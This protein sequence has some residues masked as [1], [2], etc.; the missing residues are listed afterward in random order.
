MTGR[1]VLV[2]GGR[3]YDDWSLVRRTLNRLHEEQPF[4]LVI[5]GAAGGADGL[6]RSW[7]FSRQITVAE[8]PA[9][10]RGLGKKAG[11]LRNGEMI[12]LMKPDVIIAFPGGNGTINCIQQAKN[13]GVPVIEVGKEDQA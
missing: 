6:A 12:E 5:T 4:R 1:R 7:A 3:H 10:W 13:A 11:P 8:F 2:C 9:N